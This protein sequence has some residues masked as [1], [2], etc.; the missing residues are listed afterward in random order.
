MSAVHRIDK[1]HPVPYYTIGLDWR[2]NT[3]RLVHGEWAPKTRWSRR[4]SL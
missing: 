4:R 3:E 2:K 1:L